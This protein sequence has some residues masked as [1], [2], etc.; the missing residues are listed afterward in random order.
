MMTG[1][2]FAF[3]SLCRSPQLG[4][5]CNLALIDAEKL[6][7]CLVAAQSDHQSGVVHASGQNAGPTPWLP[8]A[9]AAYT[10]SRWVGGWVVGWF[11]KGVILEL[12]VLVGGGVSS[13][14]LPRADL[15]L[16]YLP[17]SPGFW[18]PFEIH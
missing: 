7:D 13:S 16:R 1:E 3:S 11:S 6:T 14:T 10:T 9:L 5:G 15:S 17:Q 4:Q 2:K 12:R 18:Q 8:S